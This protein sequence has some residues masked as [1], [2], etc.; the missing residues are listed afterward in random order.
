MRVRRRHD[1][2]FND[3][4]ASTSTTIFHHACSLVSLLKCPARNLSARD[5][6]YHSGAI[7]R[8]AQWPNFVESFNE[9]FVTL[10]SNE[11]CA[12]IANALRCTW[13]TWGIT[14]PGNSNAGRGNINCA[15]QTERGAFSIARINWRYKENSSRS[16]RFCTK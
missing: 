14:L 11:S 13:S 12:F 1:F 9:K 15:A 6:N 10:T 5:I 7:A 8:F 4:V 2:P 16:R 3:R